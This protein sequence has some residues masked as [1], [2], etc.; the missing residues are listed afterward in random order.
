MAYLCNFL[1]YF[2]LDMHFVYSTAYFNL[3]TLAYLPGLLCIFKLIS[4]YLLLLCL[5]RPISLINIQTAA[6][7]QRERCFF[8]QLILLIKAVASDV[9]QWKELLEQACDPSFLMPLELH[10][11]AE[12]LFRF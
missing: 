5:P 3:H 6:G 8:R 11:S 2:T 1:A 10:V 9:G 7:A 4:T 12:S